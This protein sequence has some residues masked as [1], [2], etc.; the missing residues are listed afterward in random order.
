[1]VL[2]FITRSS[3][4]SGSCQGSKCS[5]G[6]GVAGCGGGSSLRHVSRCQELFDRHIYYLCRPITAHIRFV[7]ELFE[8]L[9][10]V[11][12]VFQPD[13][14]ILVESVDCSGL[15]GSH[16]HVAMLFRHRVVETDLW[17]LRRRRCWGRCGWV[18]YESLPILDPQPQHL[19]K[20]AV[21]KLIQLSDPPRGAVIA[22]NSAN[23]AGQIWLV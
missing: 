20:V 10:V 9:E 7:D 22:N 2:A 18:R 8:E 1:M 3:A 12:S 6:S 19:R 4:S 21:G 11:V 13:L 23:G 16:L 15:I 5:V 17:F 14:F